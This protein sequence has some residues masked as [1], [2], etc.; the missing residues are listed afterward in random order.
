MSVIG[1][2]VAENPGSRFGSINDRKCT[3]GL[4]NWLG[5]IDAIVCPTSKK[6]SLILLYWPTNLKSILTHSDYR[7][8]SVLGVCIPLI[9]VQSVV[10]KEHECCAMV[11]TR[12]APCG[13]GD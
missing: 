10:S 12:S 2:K 7:F 11:L 3:E 4:I 1:N 6:E 13:D 8:G 5:E 9:R